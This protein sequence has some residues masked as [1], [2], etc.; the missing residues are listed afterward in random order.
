[1][2]RPGIG[3]A[4]NPDASPDAKDK[5][6]NLS[7]DFKTAVAESSPEEIYKRVTELASQVEE[8]A[9]AKELDSDLLSAK[10]QY[11]VCNAPYKE[12]TKDL[13][14]RVKYA[15]RVLGDKGKL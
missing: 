3:T 11:D 1:M 13:K 9:T 8:L 4:P 7:D 6:K 12:Q 2:S 10:E 14:L 15:L 5:F